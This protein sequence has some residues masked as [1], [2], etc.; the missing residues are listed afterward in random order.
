MLIPVVKFWALTNTKGQIFLLN[1]SLDL[2]QRWG[3]EV[4]LF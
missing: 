2:K 1:L 4:A 3:K